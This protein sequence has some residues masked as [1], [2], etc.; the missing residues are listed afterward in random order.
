M[1]G[2][3]SDSLE[4][5]SFTSAIDL[6]AVKGRYIDSLEILTVSGSATIT[7]A[8]SDSAANRTLT[9]IAGTVLNSKITQIVSVSGV[10]LVRANWADW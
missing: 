1:A 3:I 2:R 6:Y 4:Y 10:T 7:V 5:S 8:M 9:V